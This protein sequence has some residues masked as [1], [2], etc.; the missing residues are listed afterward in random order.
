MYSVTISIPIVLPVN[1]QEFE[2]RLSKALNE[3][4]PGLAA[5]N[6][7]APSGRQLTDIDRLDQGKVRKAAVLALFFERESNA[8]LVLT[9]RTSYEGVHSDQVSFPGGRREAQDKSY[10]HTALRETEEEIGINGDQIV[11]HGQLSPL[12][13][14]PSNFL[15]YPFVG[16][17]QGQPDFSKQESEVAQIFSVSITDLL[18]D[19]LVMEKEINVRG[20]HMKVPTFQFAGYTVWGATA[21]MLSELRQVLKNS[22]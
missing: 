18:D 16:L 6:E 15:V 17:H 4:L 22:N 1:L 14:P 2:N 5:Q 11:V 12:Y 9:Q 7:M 10:L 19:R 3:P 8:Q 13:I 21:M 20:F